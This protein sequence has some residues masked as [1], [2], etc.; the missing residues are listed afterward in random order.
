LQYFRLTANTTYQEYVRAAMSHSLE[1]ERLLVPEYPSVRVWCRFDMFSH[2]FHRDCPGQGTKHTEMFKK[3]S[4]HVGVVKDLLEMKETI[5]CNHCEKGLFFQTLVLFI[6]TIVSNDMFSLCNHFQI[7]NLQ[8]SFGQGHK[9]SK[10]EH[11]IFKNNSSSIVSRLQSRTLTGRN[12]QIQIHQ[13]FGYRLQMVWKTKNK[14]QSSERCLQRMIT[15]TNEMN[16]FLQELITGGSENLYNCVGA[17]F[18]ELLEGKVEKCFK[19]LSSKRNVS[20]N[21]FRSWIRSL[22]ECDKEN[23]W[24]TCD[25]YSSYV[26]GLDCEVPY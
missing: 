19:E 16:K 6:Q 17:K 15:M 8:K 1:T 12:L 7:K 2:K 26:Y 21:I 5:W 3:Y 13:H 9:S 25:T 24:S 22:E 18:P 11:T 10:L 20:K 23:F 4:P 14:K